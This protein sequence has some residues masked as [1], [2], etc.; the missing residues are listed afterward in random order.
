MAGSWLCGANH[1]LLLRFGVYLL[2]ILVC[3]VFKSLI[4]QVV[5][6]SALHSTLHI[7]FYNGIQLQSHCVPIIECVE[8]SNL[9]DD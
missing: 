9:G 4:S 8:A 2:T 1:G 3:Q 5:L 7:S 6:K